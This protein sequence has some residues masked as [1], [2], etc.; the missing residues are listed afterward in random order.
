MQAQLTPATQI[1]SHQ[2]LVKILDMISLCQ[3]YIEGDCKTL[4]T[5]ACQWLNTLKTETEN[6]I[7]FRRQVMARLQAYYAKQVFALASEVYNA[8]RC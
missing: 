3:R 7:E 5:E 6:R 1:K 2:K 8:T 4:N